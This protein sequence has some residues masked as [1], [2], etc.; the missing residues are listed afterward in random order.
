MHKPEEGGQ[1]K[2]SERLRFD[3]VLVSACRMM[4]GSSRYSLFNTA[5]RT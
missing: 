3:H 1:V 2:G 5:V 4:Y